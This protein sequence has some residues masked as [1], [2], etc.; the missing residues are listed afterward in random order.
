MS[1]HLPRGLT[2]PNVI[3]PP[4]PRQSEKDKH[5]TSVTCMTF[6]FSSRHLVLTAFDQNYPGSSSGKPTRHCHTARS[7]WPD[8]QTPTCVAP[9]TACR[10]AQSWRARGHARWLQHLVP[11]QGGFAWLHPCCH[12]PLPRR[13]TGD[14]SFPPALPAENWAQRMACY[15]NLSFTRSSSNVVMIQSI[16]CC[17]GGPYKP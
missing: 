6:F 14:R 2:L 15:C 1:N 12:A 8:R 5:T 3:A 16:S 13:G 7:P 4:S 10:S 11:A 9:R 17:A